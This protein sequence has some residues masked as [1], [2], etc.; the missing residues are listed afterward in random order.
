M[1]L[2]IEVAIAHSGKRLNAE[3]IAVHKIFPA[4]RRLATQVFDAM[5]EIQRSKHA[6]E[7]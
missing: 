7:Q 5:A 4:P 1:V 6:V 3:I 2:R